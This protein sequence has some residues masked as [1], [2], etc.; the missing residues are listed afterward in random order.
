MRIHIQIMNG[1]E[2]TMENSISLD[3]IIKGEQ[4]ICHN[5]NKG[6][7][8]IKYPNDLTCIVCSECGYMLNITSNVIIE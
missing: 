6:K 4:V 2:L 8:I 1:K 7:L 3:D 5:C